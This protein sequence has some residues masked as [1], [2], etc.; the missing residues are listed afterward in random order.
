MKQKNINLKLH[1]DQLQSIRLQLDL[2]INYTHKG[3]VLNSTQLLYLSYFVCYGIKKG[4]DK[5]IEDGISLSSQVWSN[6]LV[7]FRNTGLI[8]GVR[9]KSKLNPNI[10]IELDPAYNYVLKIEPKQDL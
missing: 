2:M 3:I 8:H 5:I 4:R 9:E 7:L 1:I 6:N 10:K